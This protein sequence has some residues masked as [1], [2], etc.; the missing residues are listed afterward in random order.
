MLSVDIVDLCDLYSISSRVWNCLCEGVGPSRSALFEY[1]AQRIDACSPAATSGYK[2]GAPPLP[3]C[4]ALH[5]VLSHVEGTDG[6][7]ESS[8]LGPRSGL[9]V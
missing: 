7:L 1:T 3:R 2:A 5:R 6:L 4:Y 8:E 9:K